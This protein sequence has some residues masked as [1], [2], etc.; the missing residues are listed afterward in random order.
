[1]TSIMNRFLF[2]GC[3]VFAVFQLFVPIFVPLYDLQLRAIHVFLGNSIALLAISFRGKK[4]RSHAALAIDLLVIAVLFVAN[5][6]VFLNWEE[7]ITY[8]DA[9]TFDLALG[10]I[11][12]VAILEASRRATGWA[13]PIC[14]L[15]MLSYVFVGPY[16]PGIWKHPGFP[17]SHIISTIYY[18]SSGIYSSLTGTSATFIA[19]FILFGSLLEITG[20]GRTFM[21]LALLIAGRF[22]GG[23]AKV[24]VIASAMFGMISGSAVANV[25]V[26][27][28]YTIPIMRKLGYDPDFAGGV[29]SMASTGGGVTPPIMGISA[30]I[31]ADFLGI[32]YFKIMGYAV[33][34]CLLFYTGIIAGVHFEAQRLG[35]LPVP[36]AEIPHWREVFQWHKIA[37]LFLPIAILMWLLFSGYSLM[38]AGFYA[39][40]SAIGFYLLSDLRIA[41]M[42]KRFIEIVNALKDGGEALARIVPILVSVS[43]FT[44]LLGVTGVAPKISGVILE[45]GGQNLIGAL[46]VAAIIP[47]V[48]GAPLPV[49]A[50]YI[51]SAA[52]IAPALVRLN[53]DIVSA[54]MF[55]LYWATLASVTPP[56]CTA[57]VIAA[58]IS[59]GNWLK[60]S[61]VGM[62]LGIVAFL[63]P[64]FFVLNPA[65]I[66]RGA[67][68]EVIICAITGLVG[69]VFLASGFF[70]F[71][72]S[73]LNYAI[74]VIYF[75][76]GLLL[77]SP[78]TRTSLIGII[79]AIVGFCLEE[80]LIRK[81][82]KE[83]PV[84]IHPA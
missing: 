35:L 50:T 57:C 58:N 28:N 75:S 74:R 30:F 5:L 70:G 34:P 39:S 25:S 48:L 82:R 60:S 22:K 41:E 71:M 4:T 46:L 62:R 81:A 15:I 68:T 80:A 72:R 20:G 77:L 6:L 67:P 54:H 51:L 56:T 61:F 27:G 52:L 38:A 10:A 40:I 9:T 36:K 18:S 3:L 76:A 29:E 47:L 79:I 55:L 64:F 1:M 7:I 43:I 83:L 84:E 26:T 65:L 14:V 31:M 23:P 78:S 53:I 63:A 24:G 21:E 44:G 17:I 66:G 73:R 33:I 8:G 45:M 42:K 16:M 37:P 13:I 12:A 19:M 59:G 11:T 69:A 49:A 2:W 32:P